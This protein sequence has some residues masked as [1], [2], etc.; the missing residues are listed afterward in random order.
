MKALYD[1]NVSLNWLYWDFDTVLWLREVGLSAGSMEA[2]GFIP[3]RVFPAKGV[4]LT[5]AESEAAC[6]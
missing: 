2:Q 6:S 1:P 5:L 3:E 4:K